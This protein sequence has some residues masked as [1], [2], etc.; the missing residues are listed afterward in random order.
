LKIKYE[1]I[2]LSLAT[3]TGVDN[4][5]VKGIAHLKF[6]LRTRDGK[7]IVTCANFIIS[8]RLNGLEAI[9]GNEFLFRNKNVKSLSL[10]TLEMYNKDPVE[11][12][13][14]LPDTDPVRLEEAKNV[15]ITDNIKCIN[16]SFKE[17]GNAE[18]IKW[19]KPKQFDKVEI[20]HSYWKK[21]RAELPEESPLEETRDSMVEVLSHSLR[22]VYE[23]ETFFLN[24]FWIFHLFQ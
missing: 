4:T 13:E 19:N 23:N 1:P 6:K 21:S 17:C 7:I 8:S 2:K 11:Q 12:I 14:I 3:A 10:D 16:L 24:F 18:G 22:E 5:A 15:S 9:L 20:K